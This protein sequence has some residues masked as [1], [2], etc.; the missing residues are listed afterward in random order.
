MALYVFSQGC[1]DAL[2]VMLDCIV[3]RR[4]KSFWL[5]G[6]VVFLKAHPSDSESFFMRQ[7][8]ATSAAGEHTGSGLCG[9]N[10][11]LV[12][13]TPRQRSPQLNNTA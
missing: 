12:G 4:V 1:L 7:W 5:P 2:C 11:A 9:N 10:S 6:D 13:I 3:G 8:K